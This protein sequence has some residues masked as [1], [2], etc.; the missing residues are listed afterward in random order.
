MKKA[1]RESL[2]LAV[3]LAAE[4]KADEAVGVLEWRLTQ[5]DPGNAIEEIVLLSLHASVICEGGLNDDRRA[6]RILRRALQHAPNDTR[7]LL[8]LSRLYLKAGKKRIA[9]DLLNRR[10]ETDSEKKNAG[11][12]DLIE[13]MSKTLGE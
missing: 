1:S 6:R 5:L 10:R 12:Q 7:T 2:T 4:G 3:R 8:S 11:L 9:N 13:V